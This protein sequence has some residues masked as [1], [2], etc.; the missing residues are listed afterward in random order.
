MTAPSQAQVEKLKALAL[1]RPEVAK[2][3]ALAAERPE[4]AKLTALAA[5]RPEV[6]VG[7]AFVGGFLL[8]TILRLLAR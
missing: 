7:A 3:T 1:Q 2:L 4:L 6:A 5:E 8:A